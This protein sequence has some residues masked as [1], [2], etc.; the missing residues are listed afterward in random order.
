MLNLGNQPICSH[1]LPTPN[2]KAPTHP[3][4]FARCRACGQLQLSEPAPVAMLRSP[5]SWI[6]YI[7]PEG[8][9]DRLTEELS[10]LPGAGPMWRVGAV[11][12]K[13]ASMLDR[14]RK[15]GWDR[16]WQLD[17]ATDLDVPDGSGYLALIQ[18]RLTP[19][20]ARRIAEKYGRVDMLL[21]RHILENTYQPAIFLA[22]LKELVVPGGVVVFECPDAQPA[23]LHRDY[24]MIWEEHLWY[25]TPELLGRF[26]ALF[27]MRLERL[28]I[29][30]Y[31]VENALVALVRPHAPE[32]ELGPLPASKLSYEHDRMREFVADFPRQK[33]AW[34]KWLKNGS[35][36]VAAFGAGHSTCAFVNFFE[37]APHIEFVADDHPEKQGLFLPG[38]GISVMPSSK[39]IDD[40]IKHCLMGM[41][42]ESEAKVLARQGAA[43]EKGIQFASIFPMSQ[44]G[45]AV[46]KPAQSTTPDVRQMDPDLPTLDDAHIVELRDA[47]RT[48]SRFRNRFCAHASSSDPLHEMIICL[49]AKTYVRPHRHLQKA[50]S[51]HVI[52]GFADLVVF[53]EH[54]AI[55]RVI[56]LGPPGSNRIGYI[57][58]Q[59]P[60]FH[61]LVLRGENFVFHETTLGPWQIEGTEM[62]PW[63]PAETDVAAVVTY[64]A[65]LLGTVLT[66]TPRE[67]F[68][69]QTLS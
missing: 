32:R 36:P 18:E 38:S 52:E 42:P 68:R 64:K 58:L 34:Q 24:T 26:F 25:F 8:H 2:A 65:D 12:Y 22:A 27:N 47:V 20:R 23:F 37:L 51:I 30:S 4:V 35:G 57:R 9:L 3:L 33:A 61:T 7:E 16:L 63:S 29:Y 41:S 69:V 44:Y 66:R 39:L 15:R 55:D 13:D 31:S 50:E 11:T 28:R 17:P 14:F 48:S 21:A 19:E 43:L 5:H 54:G 59:R 40:G 49:H 1:F 60:V 56:Q 46:G 62:A 6:K 10:A 67:T 45:A 53:D